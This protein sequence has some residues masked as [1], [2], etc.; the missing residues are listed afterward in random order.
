MWSQLNFQPPA[1]RVA[2][3]QIRNDATAKK[4]GELLVLRSKPN[5]DGGVPG[6]R[7]QQRKWPRTVAATG[8]RGKSLR[9]Q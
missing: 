7:V 2:A 9:S 5:V 4:G 1:I 8:Y 6:D 3:H